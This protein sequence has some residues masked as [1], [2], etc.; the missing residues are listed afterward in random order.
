MNDIDRILVDLREQCLK[1]P[2]DVFD[3]LRE[4][5]GKF[6]EQPLDALHRILSHLHNIKGNVQAVGFSFFAEF[7][8][9]LETA[10][11]KLSEIVQLE[12][13]KNLEKFESQIS[14]AL[15]TME[16]YFE[17]LRRGEDDSKV[18]LDERKH[19]LFIISEVG[20]VTKAA[21]STP[22]FGF[23]DDE[24]LPAFGFF[25]DEPEL[26]AKEQ[27]ATNSG[28]TSMPLEPN[29]P[30][31]SCRRTEK[32]VGLIEEPPSL[33]MTFL[34]AGQLH[35][36]PVSQIREV[37]ESQVL[38]KFPFNRREIAGL[39][40]FNGEPLTVLDPS[41]FGVKSH[42]SNAR[43]SIIVTEANGRRF[44]ILVDSLEGIMSITRSDIQ[45]VETQNEGIWIDG[46]FKQEHQ[47]LIILSL[48]ATFG[49]TDAA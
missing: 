17:V 11:Q 27:D 8:H 34:Q 28:V 40:S 10:V 6:S 38:Q 26:Q 12:P 3:G 29:S 2:D 46:V 33:Y 1:D 4:A 31:S 48:N 19:I 41:A 18:L 49:S 13:S 30:S 36:L 20:T 24:P 47:R 37:I 22:A 45:I 44:G 21:E 25:D 16:E 7:V 23:F 32:D 15:L 9:D 14:S 35:A 39:I 5:L 43:S 42:S